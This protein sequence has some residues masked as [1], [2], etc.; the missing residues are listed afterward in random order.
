MAAAKLF[1]EHNLDAL[2]IATNAPGRSA[3]NRV[4]RRMAPLSKDLSGVVLEHQFFGNHLNDK[5]E[6]VDVELEKSNFQHAG[7]ILSD[8]WSNSMIDGYPV[9]ANYV[10]EQGILSQ[11]SIFI[12]LSYINNFLETCAKTANLSMFLLS[13]GFFLRQ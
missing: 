13:Q 5:G 9:S 1:Q 12:M 6:T 2:F 4:E 10:Q 8:I 7:R 11:L 3:Y